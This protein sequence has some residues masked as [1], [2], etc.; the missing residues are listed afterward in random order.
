M[1]TYGR[2][3]LDKILINLCDLVIERQKID[4]E[5]WGLVGV[6]PTNWD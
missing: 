1:K 5:K 6:A 4:P 2:Q 3:Q